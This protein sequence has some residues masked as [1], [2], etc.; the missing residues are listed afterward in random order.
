[1][2]M[3]GEGG[4]REREKGGRGERRAV[5]AERGTIASGTRTRR[6][7]TYGLREGKL[8]G[9]GR[10]AARQHDDMGGGF[11]TRRSVWTRTH[12]ASRND[13][14]RGED[15]TSNLERVKTVPSVRIG[16]WAWQRS[17]L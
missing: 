12:R 7:G 8:C 2:R 17:V 3:E 14:T 9:A 1:M 4:G 6:G 11:A 5:S 15:R 10:G 16:V 13:L